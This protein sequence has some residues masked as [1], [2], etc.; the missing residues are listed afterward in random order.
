MV[1]IMMVVCIVN[2]CMFVQVIMSQESCF[3]YDISMDKLASIRT[4]VMD[5]D[6][7]DIA[8]VE[9]MNNAEVADLIEGEF[10]G[11]EYLQLVVI[12]HD[13]E[14]REFCPYFRIIMDSFRA[15]NKVNRHLRLFYDRIGMSTLNACCRKAIVV[16]MFDVFDIHASTSVPSAFSLGSFHNQDLGL[17]GE[18][19]GS[20]LGKSVTELYDVPGMNIPYH[21][22]WEVQWRILSFLRHPVADIVKVT[23]DEVRCSWDTFLYPM[24]QQREPRIPTYIAYLY[25]VPTVL[26]TIAGATKSFLASTVPKP[27]YYVYQV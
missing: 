16:G 4:L 10:P 18:L 13:V 25:D 24:F 20:C 12:N 27:E 23:M 26:T 3:D 5:R 9:A 2:V 7:V 19:D 6:E 21:L 22:P 14:S 8:I 1:L 15:D 11:M 17:T